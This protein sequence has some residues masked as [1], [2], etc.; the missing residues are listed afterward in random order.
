M[1]LK[2]RPPWGPQKD[3]PKSDNYADTGGRWRAICLTLISG[4]EIKVV[5]LTPRGECH[6]TRVYF[7]CRNNNATSDTNLRLSGIT[8]PRTDVERV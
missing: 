6:L 3:P 5:E 2:S 7:S 8:C 1:H 4:M